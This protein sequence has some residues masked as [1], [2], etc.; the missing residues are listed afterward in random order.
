[1]EAQ[2]LTTLLEAQDREVTVSNTSNGGAV[3]ELLYQTQAILRL[4]GLNTSDFSKSL[5]Y[6][7]QVTSG[8]DVGGRRKKGSERNRS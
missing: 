3:Q 2:K 4:A 8:G 5:P 1:V 7:I 6:Q